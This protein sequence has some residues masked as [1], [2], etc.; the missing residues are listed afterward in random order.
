LISTDKAVR[1]TNVMGATKRISEL[2]LQAYSHKESSKTCFV[3]VRFGNVLDSNGSVVPLFRK[4]LENRQN[5]TITHEEITRYFMSITEAARLV[6]QAG[7]LGKGGEIFLL[8]MGHPVKIIELATQ[9]IEL[10]GLKLGSDVDIDV[11]GLRP[12]EKLYEELLIDKKNAS[13]TVHPNIYAANESYIP[14]NDLHPQL[15]NLSAIAR[16]EKHEEL[17]YELHKLVPEFRHSTHK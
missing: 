5:L 16:A 17:V 6:I 14:W 4:Q 11:I 2:I 13:P 10:S 9:M 8:E 15:T 12:G 3:M 7:S 1:P